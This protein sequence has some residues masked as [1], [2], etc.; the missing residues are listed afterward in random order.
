MEKYVLDT[1]LFFNME[2]GLG[3][4]EKTNEVIESATAGFLKLKK[5][6]NSQFLMPPKV[7]KELKSFFDQ[8][9]LILKKFLAEIT[10]KSPNI[11]QTS[12]PASLFYELVEEI[13]DRITRGLTVAEDELYKAV[14]SLAPVE[15]KNKQDIQMKTGLF[16]KSLRDRYRQLTRTRFLDSTADLDLIVLAKEEDAYLISTDEGVIYWG[17]KFGVKE[18]D[19]EVFGKKISQS[20]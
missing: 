10:V 20:E 14:S 7:V 13:K 19:A 15:L 11:S 5:K 17:R 18:M 12:F 16:T 9:D 4:G 3:L 8:E 6:S 2:P 1:N